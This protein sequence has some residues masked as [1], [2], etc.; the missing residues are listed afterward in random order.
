MQT[1][2]HDTQL[3]HGGLFNAPVLRQRAGA[4]GWEGG[5]RQGAAVA[6]WV[7][8]GGVSSSVAVGRAVGGSSRAHSRGGL[9]TPSAACGAADEHK[10]SSTAHQHGLAGPR[11]TVAWSRLAVAAGFHAKCQSNQQRQPPRSQ[12]VGVDPQLQQAGQGARLAPFLW[13]GRDTG[14]EGREAGVD[15]L[16]HSPLGAWS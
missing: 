11:L 14:R 16:L 12:S 1:S 3:A 5:G 10:P 6:G 15:G 8:G 4:G 7:S 9:K 2:S 13:E